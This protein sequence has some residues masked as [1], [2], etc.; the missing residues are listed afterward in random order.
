M[1]RRRW[2]IS[3]SLLFLL[4]SCGGSDWFEFSS[5]EGRFS[6]EFPETPQEGTIPIETTVGTIELH[7]ASFQ[8]EDIAYMA[9]YADYPEALVEMSSAE[10][11]L[12]GAAAGAPRNVGGQLVDQQTITLDGHPGRALTIDVGAEGGRAEARFYMVG[13]R[14]YQIVVIGLQAQALDSR[15]AR[16]LD[17]FHL[18]GE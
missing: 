15:A 8:A 2:P 6:I 5:T 1:I 7:T 18:L 9:A 12:D 11:M 4:L 3:L 14:L 13:T 16:F 17:S 10:V